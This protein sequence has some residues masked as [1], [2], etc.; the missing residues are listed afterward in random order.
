MP[1][2]THCKPPGEV[3]TSEEGSMARETALARWPKIVQDMVDDVEATFQRSDIPEGIAEG[4][5]IQATLRIMKR[6]IM[7]DKP[8]Q[9]VP[10]LT[11]RP[12][13]TSFLGWQILTRCLL[14]P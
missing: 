5:R 9:C 6:E 3:W 10:Y 12:V 13:A 1:S 7:Q 11:L 14:A 4:R 2:A 8:L